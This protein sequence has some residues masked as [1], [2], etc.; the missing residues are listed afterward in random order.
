MV[1]FAINK[2]ITLGI[3]YIK[4]GVYLRTVFLQN[5]ISNFISQLG[6]WKK[7][8]KIHGHSTH[9]DFSSS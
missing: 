8:V 4:Q 7:A 5:I 1:H 2:I 3:R 9:M 6:I